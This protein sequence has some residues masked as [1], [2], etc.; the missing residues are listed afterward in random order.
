M[1]WSPFRELERATAEKE[2]TTTPY[3]WR[4]KTEKNQ[5]ITFK[6]LV[7][8]KISVK[9]DT[10]GDF[11]VARSDGSVLYLLALLTW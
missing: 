11:A 8:K 4:F 2:M 9:S 10:L 3:V 7:R 6:D 5:W 1:F